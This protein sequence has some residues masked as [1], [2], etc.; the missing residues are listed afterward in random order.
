MGSPEGKIK[1]QKH[2]ITFTE[3]STIFD[4]PL[5]YTFED[6]DHSKAEI[7]YLT[8]GLSEKPRLLVVSHAERENRTR[9]ISARLLSRKERKIHEES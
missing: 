2:R 8:F 3:A 7:R 1:F 5:A 4:D 9:I 6:P